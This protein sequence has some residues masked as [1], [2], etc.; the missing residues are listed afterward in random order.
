MEEKGPTITQVLGI[1]FMPCDHSIHV[2]PTC[3]NKEG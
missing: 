2:G 1:V 3:K